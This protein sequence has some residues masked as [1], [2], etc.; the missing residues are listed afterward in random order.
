MTKLVYNLP[1]L[2]K[3]YVSET[4]SF[5]KIV[6]NYKSHI[7]GFDHMAFRNLK[8]D[9][10]IDETYL[11]KQTDLFEFKKYNSRAVWFKF[12]KELDPDFKRLFVSCYKGIEEDDKLSDMDREIVKDVF[13]NLD[14]KLD[15]NVY[16][17]INSKN[18]YLGWTIIHRNR[19]NHVALLVD[20]IKKFI[21]ILV[22]DGFEFNEVNGEIIHTGLNGKLLQGSLMA[23]PVKYEF[24]DGTYLVP[25]SFVE[26]VQRIDNIDG[27]NNDNAIKIMHSTNS[28]KKIDN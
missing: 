23:D 4:P 7:K 27:F 19:I 3:S 18:Q 21:D 13:N 26:F 17:L 8:K 15:H 12:K 28:I 9:D 5:S 10:M 6:T 14:K 20:D 16:Q 25:G 1:K 22:N 2:F 24:S 11:Q